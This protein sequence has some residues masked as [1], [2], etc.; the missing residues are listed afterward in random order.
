MKAEIISIGNE[1]LSGY[2]NTNA[3][4]LAGQLYEN[5]ISVQ[6]I[7][8]IADNKNAIA[9]CLEECIQNADIV[10]STGGLG[11]TKDDITKQVLCKYFKCG[12]KFS[13]SAY[14]HI[15]KLFK[16]RGLVVTQTNKKQ[17]EIPEM[18]KAIPNIM[19]TAPGLWF[20]IENKT[21][22][23]LPGVPFEMMF[24]LENFIIPK[25]KSKYKLPLLYSRTI[26]THG[27]GESF[28][29][30][31]LQ[32]WEKSIPKN[33]KLAYLPTPGIVKLQLSGVENG[34]GLTETT[35][36]NLVNTLKDVIP[37]FIFG[38]DKQTLQEIVGGQ[39]I[40]NEA[41]IS[42]AESCTGGY[43]SHLITSCPGSSE[44]FKGSI[45]AYSNKVKTKQLNIDSSLIEKHG[46][47]SKEV[48]VAMALNLRE[49]LGS[50]YS[51]AA[52]GIAGPGGGTKDKPV[53]TVWLAVASPS[54]YKA[55]KFLFGENRNI[56]IKKAALTALNMMRK[57]IEK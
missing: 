55:E 33:I 47:V 40:A 49:L 46:A 54:N 14:G 21:Y 7:H 4:W 24:M 23:A 53:G 41:T 27:V 37:Q 8:T 25:L 17:A 3:S 35:I 19:G 44:Y 42:V 13:H 12:L 22:I 31:M 5:G 56:N 1:L 15:E 38:H 2:E 29:A 48:A 36:D 45:I 50:T 57:M 16:L 32:D 52:T 11:P 10:I 9:H 34:E 28:L 43:I 18:A 30:D 39:L 6:K 20:D 26:L 51:I